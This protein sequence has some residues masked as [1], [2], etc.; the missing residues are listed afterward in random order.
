MDFVKIKFTNRRKYN[1]FDNTDVQRNQKG[2]IAGFREASRASVNQVIEQQ[3]FDISSIKIIQESDNDQ[4]HSHQASKFVDRKR[5]FVDGSSKSGQIDE[6]SKIL[7]LDDTIEDLQSCPKLRDTGDIDQEI[8]NFEKVAIAK[9]VQN[10][11]EIEEIFDE[12]NQNLK[13]N[14]KISKNKFLSITKSKIISKYLKSIQKIP[15]ISQET[16]S[17]HHNIENDQISGNFKALNTESTSTVTN[18][19]PPSQVTGTKPKK[20]SYKSKFKDIIKNLKPSTTY[21]VKQ[22]QDSIMRVRKISDMP[23]YRRIRSQSVDGRIEEEVSADLRE[24]SSLRMSKS[25]ENLDNLKDDSIRMDD[26]DEDVFEENFLHDI[27]KSFHSS[28]Y[29]SKFARSVDNYSRNKSFIEGIHD[30]CMNL[31]VLNEESSIN[32]DIK[33]IE[34]EEPSISG[35]RSYK[36]AS[37]LDNEVKSLASYAEKTFRIVKM[38]HQIEQNLQNI[39][40]YCLKDDQTFTIKSQ[41]FSPN[42]PLNEVAFMVNTTSSTPNPKPFQQIS[43]KSDQSS[44]K[45]HTKLKESPESSTIYTLEKEIENLKLQNHLKDL[46]IEQLQKCEKLKNKQIEKITKIAEK[47]FSE[48]QKRENLLKIVKIQAEISNE[49]AKIK[50]ELKMKSLE[51]EKLKEILTQKDEKINKFEKKLDSKD[52]ELKIQQK[53]ID[54]LEATAKLRANELAF[55]AKCWEESHEFACKL[56]EAKRDEWKQK[57]LDLKKVINNLELKVDKEEPRVPRKR[58]FKS[59]IPKNVNDVTKKFIEK[60]FEA[61]MVP[62][63]IKCLDNIEI[64]DN[65]DKCGAKRSKMSTDLESVSL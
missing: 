21:Q 24:I 65:E 35:R 51:V 25:N 31:S 28:P 20:I 38:N 44:P 34:D 7:R 12:P 4:G 56:Y 57:L 11:D 43:S 61:E 9:K 30:N 14:E 3:I 49:S 55:M 6:S 36:S 1:K 19:R 52:S 15:K 18:Q 47:K 33:V 32:E 16:T 23:K 58:T 27:Q 63:L 59:Q 41:G 39:E 53:K 54:E 48:V 50:T 42:S 37:K 64:T 45:I 26:G 13:E 17:G 8:L 40:H 62:R 60:N 10:F 5:K 2:F 46:K 22:D 29:V